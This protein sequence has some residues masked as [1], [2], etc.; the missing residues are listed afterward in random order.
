LVERA[1]DQRIPVVRAVLPFVIRC[2]TAGRRLQ[3]ISMHKRT[4]FRATAALGVAAALALAAPLAASAHVH[5]DPNQTPAGS[6]A[7]LT[8]RVP[9]ESATAS[10]VKVEIDFPEKTPF[11]SIDDQPVTGWTAHVTTSKLPK[12]ITTPDATITEAVT[13]VV[14]SADSTGSAIQPG[15]FQE[16]AV[17]V[18]SVPS[19]GQVMFPTHQT[20][21]DGSVVNWTQATPA[22]G[23]EPEHPAPTLYINNTP[24]ADE[25]ELPLTASETSTPAPAAAADSSLTTV[26][27]GVGIAGLVIGAI[28][29][30]IAVYA[31]SALRRRQ[32]ETPGKGH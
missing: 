27:I 6:D 29:L 10:T 11:T 25:S 30:V 32:P 7:V 17:S 21:S 13:K 24:P 16:F 5:V 3:R 20:Y 9:T 14:W 1:L 31:V 26:A 12:P 23:D 28:A 19:T 8:F 15:Q 4:I 2:A 18:E 22:S